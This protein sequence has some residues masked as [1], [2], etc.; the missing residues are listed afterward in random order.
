MFNMITN[1]IKNKLWL[2][3]CLVLGMSFLVAAFSCQPMFKSGSL[4]MLLITSFE[5]YIEENNQYT[6]MLQY[7]TSV[8]TESADYPFLNGISPS[9]VAEVYIE[10]IKKNK[11]N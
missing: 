6:E 7:V 1:K 10:K 9:N 4:D 11:K 3:I 8:A 2:T 5:N